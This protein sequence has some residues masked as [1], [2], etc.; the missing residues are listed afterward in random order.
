MRGAERSRHRYHAIGKAVNLIDFRSHVLKVPES[1]A[2]LFDVYNT[3]CSFDPYSLTLRLND[4][5]QRHSFGANLEGRSPSHNIEL[6][7]TAN[8]AVASRP[9]DLDRRRKTMI[10]CFRLFVTSL[11]FISWS[12][13]SSPPP[14]LFS[15]I[16][17]GSSAA[18]LVC[19]L[20][21]GVGWLL[22]WLFMDFHVPNMAA[23]SCIIMS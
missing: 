16:P 10:R 4:H 18:F 2:T 13:H 17:N 5:S 21:L 20:E 14:L 3:A 11:S 9:Y 23:V 12:M 19:P 7:L 1:S 15:V 6:M 8:G 22:G